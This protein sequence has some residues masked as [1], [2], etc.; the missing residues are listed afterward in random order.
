MRIRI[1]HHHMGSIFHKGDGLL[2]H[3][4]RFSRG[5]RGSLFVCHG[6]RADDAGVRHGLLA[7][8]AAVSDAGGASAYRQG[9]QAPGPPDFRHCCGLFPLAEAG[10]VEIRS[11]LLARSRRHDPRIERDGHRAD[12]IHLADRR[13]GQR[14]LSGDAGKGIPD[15]HGTRRACGA[16]FHEP[17]HPLRRHKPAGAG[18]PLGKG[19][20]ELFRQRDPDLLAG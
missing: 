3:R 10:G 14:E 6:T 18:V 1:E 8:Q 7:V 20:A 16:G 12:G 5:D 19:E 9:I 13:A 2:D 11:H 15:P 4:R 17:D